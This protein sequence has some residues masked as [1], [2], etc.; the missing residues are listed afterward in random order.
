MPANK[1]AE[2][3]YKILDQL[4]ANRYHNYS[5]E[6]L[7]QKVNE[8]LR[9][10]YGDDFTPVSIRT[11]QYDL[12]YLE[13]GPFQADIM[14]Y[15]IDEVSKKNP[16]KTIKK[17]C[18]RYADRSF[19]IFQQKM[20]DD[21][22]YLLRE[23]MALLG[24]FDGLPNL[25]RLESLRV[26]LDIKSERQI[27]S[28]T[29]NSLENSSLFGELFTVISQKQVIELHYHTFFELDNVRQVVLH[30]YLLKEYNRRWYLIAAANDSGKL[31]NFR[32]DQIDK[33]VPL[34]SNHYIPYEGDIYERF[35]DIIGVSLYEDHPLQTVLFWVSDASKEYV[36]TKP[37]HESQYPHRG[38]K[39]LTLRQKYPMLTG[40]AFFSID[41]IEN[42]ELIRELT[43]FGKDLIVLSPEN[44]RHS[45]ICRVNEMYQAYNIGSC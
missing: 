38:E 20:S 35:E 40:G 28:F 41:C 26:G 12:K 21:E 22:K 34:P 37:L 44:I 14:H 19:T 15:Q 39:E 1:N 42:Y 18:H 24:Q 5:T 6:D 32:I 8:E 10:M 4:L 43:S 11:I 23:A 9:E 17:T 25:D 13:E 33:V 30:P 7:R 29:K 27:I 45:V 3:R 36:A 16:N 31:L 2:T